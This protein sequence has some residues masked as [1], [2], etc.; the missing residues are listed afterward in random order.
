VRIGRKSLCQARSNFAA[1]ARRNE[2][3]I[4]FGLVYHKESQKSEESVFYRRVTPE[5]DL[6]ITCPSDLLEESVVYQDIFQKGEQRGIEQGAR[7]WVRRN[8]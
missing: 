4:F 8:F 2:L 7:K 5:Y 1:A 3:R 6:V